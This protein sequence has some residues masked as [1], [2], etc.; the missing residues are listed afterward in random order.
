[1]NALLIILTLYL[2]PDGQG[3]AYDG[4]CLNEDCTRFSTKGAQRF[5]RRLL[6]R[7]GKCLDPELCTGPGERVYMLDLPYRRGKLGGITPVP[8]IL[9]E[10]PQEDFVSADQGKWRVYL[11]T[12]E[13]E[14]DSLVVRL[15]SGETET[16]WKEGKRR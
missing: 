16:W 3:K 7:S 5:Y 10:Q 8:R 15:E 2:S 12:L 4:L 9:A 14:A 13:G 1:M 6:T 11:F